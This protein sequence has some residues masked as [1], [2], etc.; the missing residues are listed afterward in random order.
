MIEEKTSENQWDPIKLSRN[1]P[2]LT[3]LFFTDEIILM[4]KANQKSSKTIKRVLDSF[5]KESDQSI[6][7]S[8]SKI[9]FF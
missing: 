9:F 1:G 7:Y 5:C 2:L 8:K 4:A 3:H 6:N